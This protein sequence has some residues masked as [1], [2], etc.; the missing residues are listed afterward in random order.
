M[1]YTPTY[2]KAYELVPKSVYDRFADMSI[3]FLDPG[4]LA[5]ADCLRKVFGPC[6][7][8]NWH[9]QGTLDECGLRVFGGDQFA[10]RPLS[11]HCQGKALD[12]HF[13]NI[14]S[15]EIR[16]W[17]RHGQDAVYP[18]LLAI[19]RIEVDTAWLHIDNL[20]VDRMVW[21]KIPK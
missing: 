19:K 11:A 17:F 21:V 15:E 1:A 8:N 6:T 5:A 14:T 10:K 12:L 7:V 2:F 20:N 4:I 18:V 16:D 3:Q 13:K 9:E